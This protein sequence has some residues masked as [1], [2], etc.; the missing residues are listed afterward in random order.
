M[1]EALERIHREQRQRGQ[2]P[3]TVEE[4]AGETAQKRR[5]DDGQG[6]FRR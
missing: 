2:K 3:M 6:A 5:D 4:M 1:L